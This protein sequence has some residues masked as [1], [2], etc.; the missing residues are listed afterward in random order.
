M[1]YL[2]KL[3]IISLVGAQS[4]QSGWKLLSSSASKRCVKAFEHTDNP[5]DQI[6]SR[7]WSEA[8]QNCQTINGP[9]GV[10]HL[11]RDL[12]DLFQN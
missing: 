10:G 6:K 2:I 12:T 7:T 11:R 8:E 3:G 1:K 4:C 5:L 9:Q